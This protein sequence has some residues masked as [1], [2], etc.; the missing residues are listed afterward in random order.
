MAKEKNA[1]GQYF[2]PK[3][4]ADLM[5][6]MLA[7]PKTAPVL[8][9]SAGEGV[10]LDALAA[11][12]FTNCT[13]VEIDPVLVA[14]STHGL[15]Q[16]S[17]VSWQAPAPVTGVIGNPPYIRWKDLDATSK[18]EVQAHPLF[19]TL[20]NS[21]SDYLTVFIA[22]AVDA[23]APGGEL[24]FITPSFW[25]HTTHSAPL[26]D[27]LLARGAITDVVD[28][29][30]AAVFPGVSS[31]I[32]VFRFEKA[33]L[34]GAT[35]ATTPPVVAPVVAPPAPIQYFEYVGP[36]R[37]P[38]TALDLSDAEQFCAK[39][40]PAFTG[41]G[42]WTLATDAEMAPAL[43]LEE[44]CTVVTSGA[45]EVTRLGRYVD[46]ANGMVS[47]LDAVFR[48]DAPLLASL[49]A[50]ERAA[51]L[52]VLKAFQMTTV[53]SDTASSYLHLPEGL[54][55]AEALAAYPKVMAHLAA[56][57]DALA[58]RYSTKGPLNYWDWSF[59]R[60]S[61]FFLNGRAKGF[62]PSKE[63]LTCRDTARFTLGLPGVVATQ[64]VTAFAPKDGVRESLAY[65]VGYLSQPLVTEWVKRR[66]MMK[67]GVAEFSERPL[68]HIPFRAI[69]WEEAADVAAH[70]RITTL[71]EEY[72]TASASRRATI[73]TD[74][75]V[76]FAK[77]LAK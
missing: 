29:K 19:G 71:V 45:P 72:R 30:E 74:L 40:I 26:R 6:G 77:L 47:G 48:L 33:S 51:T 62:V 35:T 49:S 7:A 68:G 4:V 61:S 44:A 31:A 17:F 73:T 21:L 36:R 13:G 42:H 12:G 76:E 60:S 67:G 10:F 9:P 24:I 16:G 28:F 46:I 65:M 54:S 41:G 63:R 66:G 32:V 43:A 25:M 38:T 15:V 1:H 23:L 11:A 27:W 64:D 14:K 20:F 75:A 8:E 2:T 70:A 59:K 58:K 56:H 39:S 34:S 22:L 18:R 55:E 53:A 52:P 57:K 50:T 37:L 69:R 5:V 3:A